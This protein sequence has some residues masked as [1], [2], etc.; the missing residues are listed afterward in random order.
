MTPTLCTRDP[1]EP[2]RR[3]FVPD[4]NC[5]WQ[6][7]GLG[8][9]ARSSALRHV[10]WTSC[11]HLRLCEQHP[12]SCTHSLAGDLAGPRIRAAFKKSACCM[13]L[14]F[15]SMYL[16]YRDIHAGAP[17][18]CRRP[19]N[20]APHAQIHLGRVWAWK[21]GWGK[22]GLGRKLN[23][24]HCQGTANARQALCLHPYYGHAL[25]ARS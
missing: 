15:Y 17:H 7:A 1:A 23:S 5:R 6:P 10:C 14:C 18:V 13:P 9:H 11:V 16:C 3:E 4:R 25:Q 24:M 20:V 22:P 21:V 19:L 8:T 2:P 12:D